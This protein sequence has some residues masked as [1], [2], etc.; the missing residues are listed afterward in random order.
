MK[1]DD[2]VGSNDTQR[3]IFKSIY[4]RPKTVVSVAES[5]NV[6]Q[7]TVSN[8]L[9]AIKKSILTDP[10]S[11]YS[12]IKN[13]DRDGNALYSVVKKK[14]FTISLKPKIF[15]W[16]RIVEVPYIIINLPKPPVGY[17][18]W[19]IVPFG[20]I[21]FGSDSCDNEGLLSWVKWVKDTENVLVILNGDLIENANKESPGSSVFRQLIPPQ[22]QK[23]QFILL[24]AQI[25]H[26]IL[27]S[28]RGNHGNRSVKGCFLD[29]ERDI[30]TA[31][32]VEYF[33]GACYADIICEDLKWE[34]MSIHGRSQSN[35]AGGRLNVLQKKSQF[36]S[37]NIFTMGHVHDLQS[38]RDYEIVRD[39]I[40]RTLK[41]KKR[42][43]V[44]CGTTQRYW[45]S[46]AE[47][48]YLA[49]NKTG[50]PK[51]ELYCNGSRNPGD[52]HVAT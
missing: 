12:F 52:Y 28:V 1:E 47:E 35:S 21:H 40:N 43:Y 51:I 20:D 16:D 39:P 22:E 36:H 25:A 3:A 15:E 18:K 23:E 9:P 42:Y 33:E 48:W 26:R 46:Y 27:Y 50:M 19:V 37:A 34:I 10:N 38:M 49:P 17:D 44:I 24:F 6:A 31:L 13:F 29:P 30:S 4:N 14:D 41:L 5:L 7:K 2:I 11:R 8:N 45:N 32:G